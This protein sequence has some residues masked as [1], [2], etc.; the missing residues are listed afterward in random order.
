MKHRRW[1]CDIVQNSLFILSRI[2]SG[3]LEEHFFLQDEPHPGFTQCLPHCGVVWFCS[4]PILSA[5]TVRFRRLIFLGSV[6]VA[7][8]LS[9][10][11]F[12]GGKDWVHYDFLGQL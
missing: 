9:S 10:A 6:L 8:V 4:V 12:C 2:S 7:D 3:I 5:P 1:K 11:A